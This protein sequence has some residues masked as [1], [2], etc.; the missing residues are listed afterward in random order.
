MVEAVGDRTCIECGTPLTRRHQKAFCSRACGNLH[1]QKG[2]RLPDVRC[3]RC[4]IEFHPLTRTQKYCSSDCYQIG[5]V[6]RPISKPAVRKARE[7]SIPSECTI[8]G[9][10]F[11]SATAG[12]KACS[13]GCWGEMQRRNKTA[14]KRRKHEGAGKACG[15]CG[16]LIAYGAGRGRFCSTECYTASHPGNHAHRARKYGVPYEHVVRKKVMDRDGWVCQLC[17]GAIPRTARTPHPLSGEIDHVI[18]ISTGGPHT[19]A[20]VQASHRSCNRAKGATQAN[21]VSNV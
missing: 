10:R 19:Y 13:K 16:Q 3:A 5:R 9:E 2:K 6:G 8:C 20:N 4:G 17:G 21:E 18:P 14:H 15:N 7:A 12:A 11:L 1:N